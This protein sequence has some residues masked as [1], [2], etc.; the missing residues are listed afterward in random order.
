MIIEQN[1]K[2]RHATANAKSKYKAHHKIDQDIGLIGL[3][4]LAVIFRFAIL[5]FDLR[6]QSGT[7]RAAPPGKVD[8]L[9]VALSAFGAGSVLC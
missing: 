4:R 5:A 3:T 1:A 7:Q 2:N 8:F 9:G 6:E